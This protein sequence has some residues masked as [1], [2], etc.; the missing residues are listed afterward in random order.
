M[1]KIEIVK[2]SLLE[3]SEKYGSDIEK[4]YVLYNETFELA[5]LIQLGFYQQNEI[6]ENINNFINNH[7]NNIDNLYYKYNSKYLISE[8]R[9][10]IQ[11]LL[12]GEKV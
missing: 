3:F 7:F 6:L 11:K 9:E 5:K 8:I 1:E 4:A 12:N 10:D 2:V